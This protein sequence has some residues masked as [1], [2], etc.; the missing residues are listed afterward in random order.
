MGIEWES[1]GRAERGRLAGIEL[2]IKVLVRLMTDRSWNLAI[3]RSAGPDSM[4]KEKT[5]EEEEQASD[6]AEVSLIGHSLHDCQ[7]R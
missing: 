6:N 7:F 3:F 5:E 1:K 2:K 4:K